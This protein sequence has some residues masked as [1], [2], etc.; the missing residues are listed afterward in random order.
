MLPIPK[1]T[2]SRIDELSNFVNLKDVLLS[3]ALSH[4]IIAHSFIKIEIL[5]PLNAIKEGTL[6][7]SFESKFG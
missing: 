4:C 3:E 7:P 6:K 1:F 5:G 2:K